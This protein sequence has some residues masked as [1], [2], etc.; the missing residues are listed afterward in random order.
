MAHSVPSTEKCILHRGP[1]KQVHYGEQWMAWGKP[2]IKSGVKGGLKAG[3]HKTHNICF[4]SLPLPTVLIRVL[5]EMSP[6]E[7][8]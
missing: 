4:C 1:N 3:C 6:V 5:H 2:V 8:S 7:P